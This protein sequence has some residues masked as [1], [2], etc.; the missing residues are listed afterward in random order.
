MI[1]LGSRISVTQFR[2]AASLGKRIEA[3]FNR[4][5]VRYARQ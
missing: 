3:I 5:V 1:V 4:Q 2:E